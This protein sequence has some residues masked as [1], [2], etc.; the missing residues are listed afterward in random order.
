[1]DTSRPAKLL[2][3][4]SRYPNHALWSFPIDLNYILAE[5]KKKF[6]PGFSSARS[7]PP[8]AYPLW[9]ILLGAG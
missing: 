6:T 7:P 9:P 1:M 2:S 8:L 5:F 3:Q 4:L